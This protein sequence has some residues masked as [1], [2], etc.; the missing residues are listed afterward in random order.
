MELH[1]RYIAK[2][3]HQN[4]ETITHG[5][6]RNSL[7][8]RHMRCMEAKAWRGVRRHGRR[9]PRLENVWRS[10][11]EN[12]EWK[13]TMEMNRNKWKWMGK[14]R[15]DMGCDT[16]HEGKVINQDLTVFSQC[17]TM[18]KYAFQA[19]RHGWWVCM[20]TSGG[21]RLWKCPRL[22]CSLQPT[23]LGTCHPHVEYRAPTGHNLP[24]GS[25]H[26]MD[27][28]H[29]FMVYITLSLAWTLSPRFTLVWD[30]HWVCPW[31]LQKWMNHH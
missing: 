29:I 22:C 4:S 16:Q 12:G 3:N 9:S 23:G 11:M 26:L 28:R 30:T 13:W 8:L 14:W 10:K 24:Q 19:R 20:T 31:W 6:V 1:M 5:W 7:E 25:S 21:G 17:S 15:C 18:Q 27:Q 2:V